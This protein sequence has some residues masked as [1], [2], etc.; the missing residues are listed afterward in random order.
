M[1]QNSPNL[2]AR[3]PL[4]IGV[5]ATILLVGGFGTW[6]IRAT[7]AGAIIAP[8]QIQVDQNRQVVQHPDGG[9][10]QTILVDEG[11]LVAAGAP[12]IRLDSTLLRTDLAIV[13]GQ[14]FEVMARRAR[15]EAERDFTD[16]LTFD[17]ELA[18]RAEIDNEVAGLIRGQQNLFNA[19]R[20]SREQQREQLLR[21]KDQ[22]NSQ[23]DGIFAQRDAITRQL[24]LIEQ[25]LDAQKSLLDR[26]LT[27]ANRVLALQREQASLAGSIGQLTANAAESAGR[28]TEIDLQLLNLDTSLQEEAITRL[29]DLQVTES[30]LRQQRSALEERLSRLEVRAPVSGI[31]YDLSVFAE[32]S[33]IRPADPLL[34]IVPQDRPFVIAS[35]V[36]IINVD[37][38]AVGQT[39]FIRF[40]AFDANDT[41]ELLGRVMQVSP[42]AFVD[43]ATGQS[44]Y[45]AEIE[46]LDGELE[47]LGDLVLI[48]GMP[49]E[50]FIR[51]RDRSPMTY[52]LE[53]LAD[54]LRRAFRES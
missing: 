13:E 50:A 20:M 29:R 26:G 24:E 22:I 33:V 25:E 43:E 45:R 17:P 10:V 38:V 32:R 4:F 39:V 18:A 46:P 23:I 42:D 36:Q 15:M 19:R 31:I 7:L 27:Q 48:P 21:R 3:M 11:D 54:H 51:T 53:P 14:F 9:V 47:K 12:L 52:L 40:S 16:T 8:G 44:Y 30:E 5:F 6:A 37:E 1:T 41:P 34:Y 2:G 35:R 28:Q 49:V